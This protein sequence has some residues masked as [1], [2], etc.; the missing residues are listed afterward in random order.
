MVPP[1]LAATADPRVARSRAAVLEATRSILR[2]SGFTGAT[3]EAIAARSGVARTTIYRHWAE[4]NE[5]VLDAFAFE[6]AEVNFP[7]TND[8]RADL[9]FGLQTL[10]REL[11]TSEW[12]TLL[13]AMV[14]ASERDA[15][16]LTL[17]Q[18]FMEARRKPLKD[19]LQLAIRQGEIG[20]DFEV[21]TLAAVLAGPLFYRRLLTHQQLRRPFVDEVIDLVLR[22]AAAR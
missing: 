8:L 13:A 22:A 18:T 12:A 10:A 17:S 16:F 15:E 6:K 20:A 14:E 3:I 19:R 5:L 2:E 1:P 11:Q 7:A 4:R 9:S 21:E